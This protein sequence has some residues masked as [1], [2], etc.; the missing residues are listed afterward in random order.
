MKIPRKTNSLRARTWRSS[1]YSTTRIGGARQT[2]IHLQSLSSSSQ[3]PVLAN[4]TSSLV[5]TWVIKLTVRTIMI[6]RQ[7]FVC[8][9]PRQSAKCKLNGPNG[10]RFGFNS[11]STPDDESLSLCSCFGTLLIMVRD[12]WLNAREPLA[13]SPKTAQTCS[14][15]GNDFAQLYSIFCLSDHG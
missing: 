14:K 15:D 3:C 8:T 11:A 6:P 2:G 1:S 5:A 7:S 10:Q 9:L 13:T 12:W 4:A